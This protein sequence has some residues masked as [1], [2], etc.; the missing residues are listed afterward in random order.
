MG[1]CFCLPDIPPSATCPSLRPQVTKKGGHSQFWPLGKDAIHAPPPRTLTRTTRGRCCPLRPWKL[2]MQTQRSHASWHSCS[3]RISKP[4][5]SAPGFKTERRE[6]GL[7][8]RTKNI[9]IKPEWKL[10]PRGMPSSVCSPG[11]QSS[12]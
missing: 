11:G 2:E 1:G 6:F 7:S 3:Y 8:V 9:L 5:C 4:D 12:D 10:R